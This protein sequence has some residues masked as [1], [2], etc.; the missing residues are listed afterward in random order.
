MPGSCDRCGSPLIQIDHY[1]DRLTG[2]PACNLWRGDKSAFIVEVAVEDWEA[3]GKL[4]N[5]VKWTL[6]P[7]TNLT[8]EG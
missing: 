4:R 3:L 6:R 2:C 1:G 5:S 7:R 8:K